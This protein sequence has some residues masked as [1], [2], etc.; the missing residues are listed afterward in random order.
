MQLVLAGDGETEEELRRQAQPLGD[1]AHFVP[2]P[3]ANVADVLSAFDV[4]VFCPSP[5]EGAPRAVILAMLAERPCVA[6]GAEGVADIIL[7]GTGIITEPE[8]EPVALAEALRLYLDDPAR[9]AREGAEARRRAVAVYDAGA[10]A[11]KIE[12]LWSKAEAEPVGV[13]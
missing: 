9:G 2:T 7:S 1:R 4:A 5:T 6:T 13:S 12:A 11:E 8:N 3:G 10:V